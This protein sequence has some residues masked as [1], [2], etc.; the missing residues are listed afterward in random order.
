MTSLPAIS[1]HN[2]HNSPAAY[3]EYTGDCLAIQDPERAYSDQRPGFQYQEAP[4]GHRVRRMK[5]QAGGC[6]KEVYAEARGTGFDAKIMRKIV[7]VR[8]KKADAVKEENEIFALYAAQLGMQT[9]F[10]V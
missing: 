10:G 1:P 6:L 8:R 4:E 9:T 7:A 2:P 3:S 5:K